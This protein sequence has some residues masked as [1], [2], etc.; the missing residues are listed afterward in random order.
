MKTILVSAV[1]AVLLLPSIS[2]GQTEKEIDNPAAAT[3]TPSTTWLPNTLFKLGTGLTRDS[4]YGSYSGLLL[5]ITL[6]VERQLTPKFSVY[7]NIS[8]MLQTGGRYRTNDR[9]FVQLARINTD[10]GARYYYNQIKREQRGRAH[11]PFIGNY[12]ALQLSNDWYSYKP[13]Y[14]TDMR[15]QYGYDYSGVT[16]LW[17]MQ[18][19]IGKWGLFDGNV[20]LGVGNH[21]KY[22][23]NYA[24]NTGEIKRPLSPIAE[25]NIRLSLAH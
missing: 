6:G 14:A 17:G 15:R 2:F 1:A 4:G 20:G 13:Y 18:R 12:L 23:Y 3:S 24:T 9:S 5:P 16:V 19:R 10:L 11:G 22:T 8:P 7:G 21:S 25:L